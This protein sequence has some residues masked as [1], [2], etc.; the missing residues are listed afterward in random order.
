M[1]E[2]LSVKFRSR[3]FYLAFVALIMATGL[4]F[5]PPMITFW[6]DKG[7]LVILTGAQWAYVCAI[8]L[9]LY[10]GANIIDKRLN[11]DQTQDTT[12]DEQKD[13]Q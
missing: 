8:V 6:F 10:K 7:P 1:K 4:V 3:K 13:Q 12:T 5:L 11:G 2:Q 9:G